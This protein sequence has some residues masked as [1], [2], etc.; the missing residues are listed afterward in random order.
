[1]NRLRTKISEAK[2]PEKP[3]A[4]APVELKKPEPQPCDSAVHDC[5]G[6]AIPKHARCPCYLTFFSLV[7]DNEGINKSAATTSIMT[8][9]IVTLSIIIIS[10][11]ALSITLNIMT[12]SIMTLSI[13]T[14]S[15]MTLN[16]K[17]L[18]IMTLSIATFSITIIKWDTSI[19]CTQSNTEILMPLC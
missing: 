12:L 7:T 2:K 19:N 1:M 9:S 18:S 5:E 13:M 14:L 3:E 8:Q 15:I 17:T 6:C 16:I 11:M 4:A 10:I